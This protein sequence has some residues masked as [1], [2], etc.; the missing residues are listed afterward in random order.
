[1]ASDIERWEAVLMSLPRK[2][3]KEIADRRMSARIALAVARWREYWMNRPGYCGA[4]DALRLLDAILHGEGPE[5]QGE[6]DG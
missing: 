5:G 2:R 1:M 4:K 3:T 6:S